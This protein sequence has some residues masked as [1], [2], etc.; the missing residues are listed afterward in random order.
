MNLYEL[1]KAVDLTIDHLHH[2]NPEEIEVVITVSENSMGARASSAV[3]YAG[4][5]FDW[6]NHQFR[7]E[8][9]RALV[10]KGNSLTDVK[11]VVCRQSEGRNFYFCP[12]CG[13]KISKSDHYCRDCSQK[14]K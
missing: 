6:E 13:Q 8:P 3:K 12:R 10:S 1:K 9:S 4:K 11:S 14:L 7:L 2:Q 5:G